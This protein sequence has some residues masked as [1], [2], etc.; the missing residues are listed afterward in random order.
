ML[1]SSV[2]L[3][4]FIFKTKSMGANYA[5]NDFESMKKILSYKTIN[6]KNP[7]QLK[8]KME[9]IIASLAFQSKTGNFYY[10]C[11]KQLKW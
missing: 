4:H 7:I 11:A 6:S 1:K 5:Y 3:G 8:F 10:I 9:L 2:V